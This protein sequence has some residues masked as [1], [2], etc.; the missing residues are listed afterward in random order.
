MPAYRPSTSPYQLPKSGQAWGQSPQSRIIGGA[1]VSTGTS[2]SAGSAGRV[3]AF[4][5]NTRGNNYALNYFRNAS[6]GPY[7]I[8]K[9]QSGLIWA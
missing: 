2:S 5:K 4:L 8:N 6:F 1:L 3:Y 9:N 7:M